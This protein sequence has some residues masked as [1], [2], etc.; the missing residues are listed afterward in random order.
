[1]NNPTLDLAPYGLDEQGLI[2]VYPESVFLRKQTAEAF[3][4]LR[5]KAKLNGYDIQIESAYRSFD[6]QVSI[7]NRKANRELPLL[8]ET[9][10]PIT[11]QIHDPEELAKTILIWSALPGAS[12]HHFGTD[13]DIVDAS[14]IPVG[15]EVQLTPE[16]C[17]GMFSS[18]HDYLSK[19]IE[20]GNS[21]GFNRVFVPGR[22]S[23]R[24]EPWHL[25]YLPEARLFQE[26][27][28]LDVLKRIYSKTNLA[29]KEFLLDNLDDLA[30]DYIF[31]YFL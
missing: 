2:S 16:E 11:H 1:M 5:N 20:M 19:E 28:N 26:H 12:R 30:K 18:F 27:F 7:W 17:N 10:T 15:Y 22:G 3:V 31:P 8:D 9:G 6:R 23:I 21:F 25:S 13:L 4:L 14:S 24:P 29:C